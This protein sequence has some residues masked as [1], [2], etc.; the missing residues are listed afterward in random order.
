MGTSKEILKK[1]ASSR[2]NYFN[3]ADGDEATVKFLYAEVVASHFDGGKTDLVRYH[4]EVAG[5]EQTF[6]RISRQLAEQMSKINEGDTIIIK[7]TGEKNKTRYSV[8]KIG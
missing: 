6:D 5:T 1:Y 3:L 4:F 7:R 2:S 8:R